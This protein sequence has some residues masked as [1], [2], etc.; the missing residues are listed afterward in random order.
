MGQTFLAIPQIGRC[1]SY[2]PIAMIITMTKNNL[3]EISVYLV[4]SCRKDNIYHVRKS[5]ASGMGD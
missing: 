5:M 1:I 3:E 4:Y 2:F